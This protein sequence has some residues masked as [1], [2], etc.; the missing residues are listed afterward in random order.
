MTTKSEEAGY[1]L[2]AGEIIRL[3]LLPQLAGIGLRAT[4]YPGPLG[5]RHF[6]FLAAPPPKRP[7]TT[8]L[9]LPQPRS[10]PRGIEH[11]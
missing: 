1:G 3:G 7:A 4:G 6:S 9:P 10:T 8:P 5:A 11:A 2:E